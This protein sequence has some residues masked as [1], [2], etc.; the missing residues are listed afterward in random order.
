[1][2]KKN[3]S[4]I[5]LIVIIVVLL[6]FVKY[7]AF[8]KKSPSVL[9]ELNSAQNQNSE[10]EVIAGLKNN[11]RS[12]QTLIPLRPAYHNQEENKKGQWRIPYIVQLIGKDN[13]MLEIEDDN[14]AHVIILHY[15]G[16]KFS[17]LEFFKNRHNFALADYQNLIDKYGDSGSSASTYTIGLVRDGKIVFFQ[18]LTKVPEN[19]FVKGYSTAKNF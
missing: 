10:L 8:I 19:I 15:A 7:F 16:G 17:L 1:M 6:V 14:N 13:V 9:P 12:I 11:W 5:N 3:F 4:S 2:K 18:D